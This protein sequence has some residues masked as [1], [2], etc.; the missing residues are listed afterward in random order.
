[1]IGVGSL[2]LVVGG[3]QEDEGLEGRGDDRDVFLGLC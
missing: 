2:G 3:L 1:M